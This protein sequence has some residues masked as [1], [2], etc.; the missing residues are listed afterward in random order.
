[1]QMLLPTAKDRVGSEAVTVLPEE[2]TGGKSEE[3][4]S[5]FFGMVKGATRVEPWKL[6]VI[7]GC[8]RRDPGFCQP[9]LG[10]RRMILNA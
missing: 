8:Q 7:R 5:R 1:M 9:S 4:C 6:R 10:R 3:T 2:F